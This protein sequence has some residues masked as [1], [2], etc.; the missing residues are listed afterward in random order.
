ML[1][2]LPSCLYEYLFIHKHITI[3]MGHFWLAVSV[4]FSLDVP[5]NKIQVVGSKTQGAS[6]IK[7]ITKERDYE[8]TNV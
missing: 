7:Q 2:T 8:F 5:I 4:C 1:T 6:V 3:E